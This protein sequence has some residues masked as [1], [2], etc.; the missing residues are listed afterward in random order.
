MKFPDPE[1]TDSRGLLCVGGDLSPGTLESA[2]VRGIFP[3]PLSLPENFPE[4]QWPLSLLEDSQGSSEDV[5]RRPGTHGSRVA[6]GSFEESSWDVGRP[7]LWFCPPQRG[8]LFFEEL[9]IPKSTRKALK[10]KT[11][12]LTLNR[13]FAGVIENCAEVSR[14]GEGTWILPEMISAYRELHRRQKAISVEAW[15]CGELAGGLYGV[16]IKGV[17]SGESM[18]FKKSEASKVCLVHLIEHLKKRGHRWIDIQMVTPV[19]RQFGGRLIPRKVFLDLLKKR[20][21]KYGTL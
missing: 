7:T 19:T 9:K 20:Q 8:V 3:W 21:E 2:Y 10:R 13:D 14:G 4:D 16:L 17:F 11:F 6:Q 18:F 1:L 12:E 5:G 15:S